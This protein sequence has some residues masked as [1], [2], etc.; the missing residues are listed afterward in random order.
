MERVAKSEIATNCHAFIFIFGR[1]IKEKVE[2]TVPWWV[3]YKKN[4]RSS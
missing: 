3:S 2:E 1:E 4:M